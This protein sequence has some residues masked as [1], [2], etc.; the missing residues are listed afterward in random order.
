MAK[1]LMEIG[2]FIAEGAEIVN[3][4]NSLSGN[5]TV[6]SPL[7]LNVSNAWVDV[8]NEFS[9]TTALTPS[10]L[11]ATYNPYLGM[12]QLGGSYYCGSTAQVVICNAPTKYKPINTMEYKAE[13]RYYDIPTTTANN[14]LIIA[15]TGNAQWVSLNLISACNNTATN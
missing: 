3:H 5:G 10:H 13:S 11:K 4:D 2:G 14:E 6:D 7:G 12:V 1:E 8:S 15:R 9:A